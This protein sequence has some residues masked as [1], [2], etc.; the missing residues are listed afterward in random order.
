MSHLLDNT[1]QD[2]ATA[3]GGHHQNGET[4]IQLGSDG[5]AHESG[6]TVGPSPSLLRELAKEG[7]AAEELKQAGV[8]LRSLTVVGFKLGQLRDAGFNPSEFKDAGWT[9]D[10]LQTEGFSAEELK[11]AGFDITSMEAAGFSL[12]QLKYAGFDAAA[13]KNLKNFRYGVAELKKAGFSAKEIIEAGQPTREKDDIESPHHTEVRE[14]IVSRIRSG[15]IFGHTWNEFF[16]FFAPYGTRN[17]FWN[18]LKSSP[19]LRHIFLFRSDYIQEIGSKTLTEETP[20]PFITASDVDSSVNNC[21]L[22]C[23]LLIGIPAGLVSNM[24]SSELYTNMITSGGFFNLPSCTLANL[25][26]ST[27]TFDSCI[28]SFKVSYR[29]LVV[30]IILSF[31][32]SIFS[33]L[34]A[35]MYYMC[36]PAESYNIASHLTLLEAFTLE[37]RKRIRAEMLLSDPK[38]KKSHPT[39]PFVDRVTETEVFL[40]A[41]HLAQNEAEEQKNQE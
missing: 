19:M 5:H 11:Q 12:K 33:L 4:M 8:D 23:A 32:T 25:Q 1:D 31:Y 3:G 6:S 30:C 18:R 9:L 24:G 7:F 22:I 13:F 35:V 17:S 39:V 37:V 27:F 16:G 10:E 14:L 38:S 2:P 40:K 36:R 15:H 21:A 26:N 20:S 28:D 41:S 29:S 34:L